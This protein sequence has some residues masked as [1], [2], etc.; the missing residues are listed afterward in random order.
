TPRASIPWTVT[1]VGG[2]SGLVGAVFD[3]ANIWVCDKLQGNLFKLDPAGAV[4]LTVTA[5]LNP[6]YPVFDGANIWVPNHNSASVT[7]FRASN[8]SG[9]AT[10]TGNGLLGPIFAAFDG[11]RIL[12]L[13]DSTSS[14]SL[15]NA[16]S[17]APLGNVPLGGANTLFGACSDGN[18]FWI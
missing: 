2:F 10:L 8:G 6:Q 16:S 7:V 5:G 14:V 11:E 12:V 17:L 1:T 4:L 15:W 9:L 3:G 18:N 13:N